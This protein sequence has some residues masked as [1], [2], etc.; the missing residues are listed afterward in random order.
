MKNGK[1]HGSLN[2]DVNTINEEP[3]TTITR[4]QAPTHSP[5]RFY[6]PFILVH[7]HSLI[8][9]EIHRLWLVG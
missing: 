2:G 5:N 7:V 9:T 3:K 6:K 1:F 4:L 8:Q